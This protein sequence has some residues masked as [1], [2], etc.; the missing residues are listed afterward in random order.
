[1]RSLV[2]RLRVE[3]GADRCQ[4]MVPQTHP[5]AAEAE[6]DFGEFCRLD[7]RDGDE[8]VH[9]LHAAVAFGKAFHFAYANQTQESFLDGHVRAFEAFGGVPTGMIR[10]DNLKPAVIRIA[11]GRERF[12]HPRFVAMRS[13]YGYRLVLLRRPASRA[14]MRRAGWRVR[15]AGSAA[16]ISPRSRTCG[17]WRR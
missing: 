14:R 1:M 4:V 17:R 16:A 15:S 11:L 8:A 6:V 9:V 10:Y 13:H 12:E 2:A 7:R 5:P 3:I